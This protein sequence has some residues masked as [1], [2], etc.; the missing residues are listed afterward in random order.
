MT[1]NTHTHTHSHT[2]T[3][4]R[5]RFDYARSIGFNHDGEYFCAGDGTPVTG[6][7]VGTVNPTEK[8]NYQ[9]II[10]ESASGRVLQSVPLDALG[11]RNCCWNPVRNSLA[12]LFERP[13][14]TEKTFDSCVRVIGM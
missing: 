6:S 2:H 12:Y 14:R 4:A 10:G 5:A 9:L 11:V 8:H 13:S 1:N 3:N 7:N